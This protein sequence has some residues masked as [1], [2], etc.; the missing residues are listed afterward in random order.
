MKKVFLKLISITS[1]FFIS[2]S[3]TL[4]QSLTG[5]TGLINI[6]T[7]EILT[8]GEIAIGA[9]F[10]NRK[11]VENENGKYDA[12]NYYV[13]MGFL[14]ILEISLRIT[15]FINY[16]YKQSLGDR[17]P[18]IRLKLI[19]E[20]EILPSMLIG[21]HDFIGTEGAETV[22]YNSLY[23]AATKNYKITRRNML[24]IH[25]G[26]GVD[27]LEARK[28]QLK[29]FFGGISCDYEKI[30]RI[31]AEY[32]SERINFGLE[33]NFLNHVKIIAALSDFNIFNAG[34]CYKFK[35]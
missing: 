25:L 28:H 3:N 34:I 6:P 20:S 5:T 27:W 22:Y 17:M 16:P 23:M 24:S 1:V 30:I 2:T 15:R 31:M 32:D 4:P 35:L 33:A 19:K 7:A 26:Y 21:A 10:M 14:P 9:N 29:G 11:I 13:T 18:S 8:D 12:V